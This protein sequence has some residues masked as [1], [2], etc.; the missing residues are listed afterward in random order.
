V[1]LAQNWLNLKD[2]AEYSIKLTFLI[3]I[4]AS[5]YEEHSAFP[6]EMSFFLLLCRK[7]IG[8]EFVVFQF[9]IQQLTD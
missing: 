4:Q 6:L 5:L 2:A 8:A 1:H 7:S 9:A 3:K